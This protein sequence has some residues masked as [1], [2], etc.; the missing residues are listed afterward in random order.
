MEIERKFLIRN[1]PEE[2]DAYP[3][4]EIEQAYLCTEPVIRIRKRDDTYILTYKGAGLMAREE[5]EFPL[6]NAAYEHLREK[7]DGFAI[8]KTRY[9]IPDADGLTIE[10]DIFSGCFAGFVMAEVEFPDMETAN[11]YVMPDW[12]LKEVTTDSRFHNARLSKMSDEERISFL[13][14]LRHVK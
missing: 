9:F 14:Y 6:T 1:L 8:T 4:A 11:A 13:E 10:L 2:L 7:S 12:F 5:H 3:H